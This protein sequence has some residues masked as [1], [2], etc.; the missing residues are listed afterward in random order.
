MTIRIISK[1]AA[2]FFLSLW[3]GVPVLAQENQRELQTLPEQFSVRFAQV[4]AEMEVQKRDMVQLTERE[5]EFEGLLAE[6]LSVR[7]DRIW[8]SVFQNT[9]TLAV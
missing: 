3:V 8:A 9:V 6:I 7:R 4:M 5:A 1:F 2:C